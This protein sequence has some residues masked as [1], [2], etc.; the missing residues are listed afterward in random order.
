MQE[1]LSGG[2]GLGGPQTQTGGRGGEFSR[3]RLRSQERHGLPL[4]TPQT[5]EAKTMET[6][7]AS[8]PATACAAFRCAADGEAGQHVQSN[9]H[10]ARCWFGNNDSAHIS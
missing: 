5:S 1:S 3:L 9:K 8:K 10:P 4:A 6:S 2:E 7:Q